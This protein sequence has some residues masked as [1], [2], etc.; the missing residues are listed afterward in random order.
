M[1]VATFIIIALFVLS[2]V[3]LAANPIKAMPVKTDQIE[4]SGQA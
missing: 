3:A 2:S 1:K 4:R